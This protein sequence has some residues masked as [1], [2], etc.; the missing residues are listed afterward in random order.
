D[1]GVGLRQTLDRG[2][3]LDAD[4]F[5]PLPACESVIEDPGLAAARDQ[6]VRRLD[7]PVDDP[8]SVGGVEC[9]SQNRSQKE[10]PVDLPGELTTARIQRSS[11]EPLDDEEVSVCVRAMIQVA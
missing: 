11:S 7:V 2:H 6:D 4:A 5:R 3:A 8:A 10:D 1:D 9:P